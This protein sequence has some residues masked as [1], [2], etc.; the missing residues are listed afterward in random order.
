MRKATLYIMSFLCILLLAAGCASIGNPSGGPRDE[1]PPRFVSS[2]PVMGEV[3]V[4]PKKIVLTFDELVTVKDAFSKVVVSPPGSQTPR[5]S[6]LGRRVTVELRDTLLP[7]TTYTIDFG[8]AIADNNEGNKLENFFYTFSTGPQLDS[9]MVSGMVLSAEDLTPEAGMYVGLHANLEDSAFMK[10]RFD[11]IAK[12]D[13]NGKFVI[14]GLAPGKY[15]IYALGDK[16]GDLKWSSPEETLAFYDAIVEPSAE[17]IVTT[18]TLFNLLTGEVDSLMTRSR[19]RFGPNNILLRSYNTGFRQQYITKYER[20]DSTRLNFIFNAPSDSMPKIDIVLSD[21][22]SLPISRVAI[23]ERSAT[24]DTLSFWLKDYD[25]ISRDTL[26]VAVEYLRPDSTYTPR[27]VNDTLRMLAQKPN[28]KAKKEEKK[29]NIKGKEGAD[30]LPPPVPTIEIRALSSKPE[31][32]QMLT[33]EFPSPLEEL[34][35][36][37][38]HLQTKK[39]SLWIDVSDFNEDML[40]FDTLNSR[41]LSIDYPWKF[42]TTYKLTV[43]SLAGKNIY[44]IF[45]D[46]FSQEFSI[47][48]E[49]E[50]GTIKLNLSNYGNQEMPRFVQLLDAQGKPIRSLPLSN[51]TVKFE[52]LLPSKYMARVVEDANGNGKWDPGIF[53]LG[54]QPDVTYYFKETI[55]LKPNWD[56]EVDWDVFGTNVDKML[57]ESLRKKKTTR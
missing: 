51:G 18:D 47:R 43:D 49:T 25:I 26:K 4:N 28:P 22:T 36:D 5:V 21:G 27:P 6:S 53:E 31:V 32:Y 42:E 37:M 57:P 56:Q 24:N 29:S 45:T 40:K 54:Q 50:Y 30:S 7:N 55:D 19:T 35:P 1:D 13:E 52:Y 3:D 23:A 46:D 38:F 44:G 20:L 16:D 9:L 39:D 33:L 11:R 15:R 2:S 48:P 34:N 8:D 12:T 41:R 14:G 17:R 10:S